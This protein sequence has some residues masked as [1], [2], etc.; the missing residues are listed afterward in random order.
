MWSAVFGQLPLIHC[1]YVCNPL[2]AQTPMRTEWGMKVHWSDVGTEDAVGE[3]A[4]QSRALIM[5]Q[6][7]LNMGDRLSINTLGSPKSV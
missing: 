4:P 1:H 5:Q 6:C 7:A 3:M 2:N